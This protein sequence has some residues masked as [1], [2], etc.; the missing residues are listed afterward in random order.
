MRV[1]S[2]RRL[3]LFAKVGR[4][5]LEARVP[6]KC[7]LYAGSETLPT[8]AGRDRVSCVS[9]HFGVTYYKKGSTE[10]SRR[11]FVECK[12]IA[13]EEHIR[14][15]VSEVRCILDDCNLH[16][17]WQNNSCGSGLS[18]SEFRNVVSCCLFRCEREKWKTEE[19]Y[20]PEEYK[21]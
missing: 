6:V 12:K 21:T 11:V 3:I 19:R 17:W 15:W 2:S 8:T 4:N 7:T 18:P 13:E 20:E 14:N 9:G 1:I 10:F 5:G 16:P